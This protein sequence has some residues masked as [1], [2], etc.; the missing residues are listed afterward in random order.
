MAE[1]KPAYRGKLAAFGAR[2]VISWIVNAQRAGFF[3]NS[4]YEPLTAP[5]AHQGNYVQ[6]LRSAHRV[7]RFLRELWETVQSMD[8]Y[9]GKTTLFFLTDHGRGEAPVEWK[10]HGEKIA[11]SKFIW[12]AFLGPDT[13]ALGGAPQRCAGDAHSDRS[14]VGRLA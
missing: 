1:Q 4:G 14:H 12:M 2:G 6:Y 3:A 9:R 5:P 7:D 13:R 11:D 10:S 8:Q